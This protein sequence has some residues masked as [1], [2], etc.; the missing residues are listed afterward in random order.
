MICDKMQNAFNSGHRIIKCL[1]L[2]RHQALA[3]QG[4]SDH[5]HAISSL[6][7]KLVY[8]LSCKQAPLF[9]CYSQNVLSLL[10]LENKGSNSEAA[11][12]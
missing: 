10:F 12:S 8:L 3:P 11:V 1:F 5:F 6:T 9:R 2:T 4:F 7:L